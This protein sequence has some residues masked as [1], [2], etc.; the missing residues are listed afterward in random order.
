[1]KILLREFYGSQYL[2]KTAKYNN[3]KFYVEGED[4]KET[5]IVSIINDNRKNYIECSCCG[6]VFR[7]GDRR[8][9]THKENAI[10]PETCFDCP[11]VYID[12][13][14]ITKR[15]LEVNP[16]GDFIEKLERD[17][18]LFCYKAIGYTSITSD[19]A[20]CDC[21]K[22]QCADAMEN[23]IKDF[24]IK[25]PGVFDDI[26]TIDGLLDNGYNVTVPDRGVNQYDIIV[27]DEYTIGVIINNIGIIDRF[28]VWYDG[29]KYV[30]YY[31]KR[32]N[33]LLTEIGRKYSIWNR[34]GLTTEMRNEIK[35][36]IAKLYN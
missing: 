20:I 34:N 2:W 23:E 6:Q 9:Q 5:N 10:K 16:N 17:V 14:I 26:I 3:G 33:E 18:K 31:S 28:Y 13:Q 12:D 29:D 30:V 19:R 36:K 22:R 21:K 25:N 27:E 4:V 35:G 11:H 32:Y 24:F 7:R 15:K 8:F 1:M